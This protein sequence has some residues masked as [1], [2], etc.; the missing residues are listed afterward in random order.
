MQMAAWRRKNCCSAVVVEV[1]PHERSLQTRGRGRG[2][3]EQQQ[4]QE[5][6]LLQQ[7][8]GRRKC[9]CANACWCEKK[10][11]EKASCRRTWQLLDEHTHTQNFSL[12]FKATQGPER[13]NEAD[14]MLG[15]AQSE[16][17]HSQGRWGAA[18]GQEV[19]VMERNLAY[20]PCNC[21]P[22]GRATAS[23]MTWAS[24]A[25]QS[26]AREVSTNRL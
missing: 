23:Q 18:E 1:Q 4:Q 26:G 11:G 17:R 25:K 12:G 5:R 22:C 2:R 10:Q 16:T 3:H 19:M 24:H 21:N 14:R 15:N 6:V 8:D 13:S 7:R 9:C 20:A